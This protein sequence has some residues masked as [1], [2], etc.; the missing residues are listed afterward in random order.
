MKAPY[1]TLLVLLSLSMISGCEN[2]GTKEEAESSNQTSQFEVTN[3]E[4]ATAVDTNK[5]TN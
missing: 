5:A 3:T 1:N 2:M 4:Q